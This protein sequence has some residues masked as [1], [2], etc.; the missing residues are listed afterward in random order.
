MFSF[1]NWVSGEGSC[2]RRYHTYGGSL[3]VKQWKGPWDRSVEARVLFQLCLSLPIALRRGPHISVPRALSPVKGWHIPIAYTPFSLSHSLINLHSW[4]R[5]SLL[6]FLLP[7]Q[8]LWKGNLSKMGH[9][10][11]VKPMPFQVTTEETLDH[12]CKPRPPVLGNEL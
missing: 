6:Y 4:F 9:L 3:W 5:N 2:N 1:S 7:Y 8:T 10:N 12:R 11:P